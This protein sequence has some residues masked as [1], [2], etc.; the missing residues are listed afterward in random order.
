[1]QPNYS[2]IN[3]FFKSGWLEYI[4]QNKTEM[5]GNLLFELGHHL[6]ALKWLYNLKCSAYAEKSI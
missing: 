1:M 4:I 6:N 2:V 3:R 5:K